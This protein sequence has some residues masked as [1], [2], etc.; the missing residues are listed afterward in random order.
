MNAAF[1]DVARNSCRLGLF[2]TAIIVLIA[3]PVLS[4]DGLPDR[5]KVTYIT[6]EGI[7]RI[8]VAIRS[9][10]AP[11]FDEGAPIVIN[12]S[13][14]FTSSSGF[15]VE[16]D[17][18]ALGAVYVTYLWPGMT[19][20]RS[21]IAS[22]GTYDYGGPDCLAAL[23]DV[24]RFAVGEGTDIDGRTID[25][26]VDVAV[27][28]DVAGLYAFS[29]SGIAATNL[30][31]LHGEDLQRIDFFVGR[32]NPT[33]DT[34]YPLEPGYWDDESGRPVHN[35]FYDPAG[36]TPT[37]IAIDYSTVYWLQS[38]E[39]PEGRPAFRAASEGG[40]DF[41]CSFK[42]PQMYGKDYWSSDLLQ[43]L[44]DS[45]ALTRETWPDELATPDEAAANWPF[46]ETVD[47][48]PRLAQV[49][50]D[51]RVMLVFASAD[52]VQTA[53]DKPHIHQ[54]YDGFHHTA[55]LWCRLNPD[56]SYVDAFIGGTESGTA[57]PD[58]PANREPPTWMAIRSWGY[59]RPGGVNTNVLVPLA[60]VA[61]MLDRTYHDRWEPDLNA[62]I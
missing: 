19:D 45:G 3:L 46:R 42:H 18:D 38:A 21:G 53:I 27:H 35:P 49:L 1:P 57:I 44:L 36:Y 60:A 7:G 33:I 4:A 58:N 39:Y 8:A 28:Y 15:K 56:R 30:L 5:T 10:S 41:I 29:H 55:G 26:L 34:L 22:E 54:A 43:A 40:E 23:R 31:A 11:R 59:A 51:L 62:I 6:S 61:E 12:V 24:V 52:H 50:P 17:P 14:F 20:A 2:A 13:G 9:P 47:S 48:Y 37:S 32:E 25:A 16:L